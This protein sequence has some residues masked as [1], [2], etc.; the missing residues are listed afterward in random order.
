MKGSKDETEKEEEE[1]Q[2]ASGW[3]SLSLSLHEKGGNI[4][5]IPLLLSPPLLLQSNPLKWKRDKWES[6]FSG[7]VLKKKN[8][9]TRLHTM[10]LSGNI[11]LVEKKKSLSAPDFS[12]LS[13]FDCIPT[14]TC[15][16]ISAAPQNFFFRNSSSSFFL[17]RKQTLCVCG[18]VGVCAVSQ[19]SNTNIFESPPSPGREREKGRREIAKVLEA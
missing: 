10:L 1:R 9:W 5:K 16:P 11:G 17:V 8:S 18:C 15:F 12:H 13:S 6:H 2:Y 4:S 19:S 14:T 3:Q 7:K